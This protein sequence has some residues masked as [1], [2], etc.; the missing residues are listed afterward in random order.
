MEIRLGAV[1]SIPLSWNNWFYRFSGNMNSQQAPHCFFEEIDQ[2]ELPRMGVM[3]SERDEIE[4]CVW[5]I[6]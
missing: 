6:I 2:K 5:G 3:N 4:I 1:D